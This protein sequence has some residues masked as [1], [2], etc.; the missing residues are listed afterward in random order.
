M[1]PYTWFRT[2]G[3]AQADQDFDEC[4]QMGSAM[5][6]IFNNDVGQYQTFMNRC[7]GDNSMELIGTALSNAMVGRVTANT[8]CNNRESRVSGVFE[9]PPPPPGVLPLP[10]SSLL[11]LSSLPPQQATLKELKHVS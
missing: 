3:A 8:V 7:G 5:R 6:T 10:P 1:H 2:T 4:N 9:L 11:R